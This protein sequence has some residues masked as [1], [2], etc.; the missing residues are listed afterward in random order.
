V[1]YLAFD[2]LGGWFGRHGART[3][4]EEAEIAPIPEPEPVEA[5]RP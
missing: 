1:I 4:N 3:V 2:R 5:G